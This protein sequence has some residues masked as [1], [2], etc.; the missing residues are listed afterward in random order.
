MNLLRLM[1]KTAGH[2]TKRPNTSDNAGQYPYPS[3]DWLKGT[4]SERYTPL[5]NLRP[6]TSGLLHA[7]DVRAVL[8][9]VLVS[10]LLCP[11]PLRAAST[12]LSYGPLP[13]K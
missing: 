8:L 1:E 12:L 10:L 7:F 11:E 13:T 2:P 3:K 9:R 6:P 4:R 5:G